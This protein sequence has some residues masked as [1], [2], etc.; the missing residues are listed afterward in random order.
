M[1]LQFNMLR[2]HYIR[3]TNLICFSQQKKSS[4]FTFQTRDNSVVF[5]SQ[6]KIDTNDMRFVAIRRKTPR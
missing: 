5:A 6:I 4:A 3:F 1:L 2:Q